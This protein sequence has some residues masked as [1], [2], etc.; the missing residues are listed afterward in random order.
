MD[1]N[2]LKINHWNIGNEFFSKNKSAI[3]LSKNKDC[4]EYKLNK[5][6]FFDESQI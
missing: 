2:N 4:F 3:N 6:D 5:F 1:Q